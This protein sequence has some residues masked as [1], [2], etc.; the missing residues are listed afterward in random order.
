MSACCSRVRRQV[1]QLL[2]SSGGAHAAR[3]A[4]RAGR[5]RWGVLAVP[6]L[7]AEAGPCLV[8]YREDR[9]GQTSG[10]S[11][12][13]LW[14]VP[15]TT[16]WRPRGAAAA[17]PACKRVQRARNRRGKPRAALRTTTGTSGKGPAAARIS[18]M[19][20]V[21]TGAS[22]CSSS[23]KTARMIRHP[24]WIGGQPA[25]RHLCPG[26]PGP[27]RPGPAGGRRQLDQNAA[28]A[29]RP[30][31]GPA[32]QPGDHRGQSSSWRSMVTRPGA[33]ALSPIPARS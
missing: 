2:T 10:R 20:A 11:P 27:G 5:S 33:G 16:T 18:R 15:S 13:M 14:P 30:A 22:S 8:G 12:G 7:S 31:R 17:S 28:P 21:V 24:H 32:G 3:N 29:C 23:G 6:V 26:R 1:G 9:A 25:L 19:A 4:D